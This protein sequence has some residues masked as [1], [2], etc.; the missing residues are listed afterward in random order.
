MAE[1]RIIDGKA[2]AA[3]LRARVAEGVAAL[4]ASHGVTPGLA[5]VLVGEDP[6]SQVY[7]R[8]KEKALADLGMNSFDHHMPADLGEAELLALIDRLNAD[9][10]VHGI[11]VQLPLPKHIDTQKILARIVPE[12]DA[13]GFHVVNAGLLA[14]GS[15]GAI[16]PCTPLG[17]LLLLRDTLG[18]DLKGKRALVLGRSNIVGKPMAQLLLQQD[19]TVTVAHSRTQDLPGECRRADILVAAVGRPEMVR[20]DWIKPGAV[21]IDVGINRV[22]HPTEP[23]KTKLVG[24]VAYDEAVKVAGAITPVPGGVGPMTIACLMLNTLAAA[25]RAAG[26]PVPAEALA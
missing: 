11:L 6:A 9:P 21:V 5:V 19:C 7:V 18:N 23:G 13:D 3:G 20:G 25:C 1:A 12:K 10:A 14:T 8:S 17:S 22:P 24:D 2:F 15:P 16:V 4:K 26:A